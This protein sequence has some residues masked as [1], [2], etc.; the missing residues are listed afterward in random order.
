[1]RHH[2]KTK[3]FNRDLGERKSLYRNLVQSLFQHERII[4]TVA[5]AK[6]IRPIA[7][8]L[9]TKAKN[10]DLASRRALSSYLYL[11]TVAQ[12]LYKEIAPRF[13][14]RAG[15]YLRIL[16]LG[17]RKSDRSPMALIEL[18][19][20]KEKKRKKTVITKVKKED[21]NKVTEKSKKE[22]SSKE[23]KEDNK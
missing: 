12:K 2:V 9:I 8:K 5:K 20:R 21:K 10:Q 4:T 14:N 7:E 11:D 16:K 23:T 3:K 1:M 22:N 17:P 19:D 6:S 18:V 13:Q 15:G